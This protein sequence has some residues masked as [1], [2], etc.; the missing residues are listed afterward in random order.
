MI[1]PRAL[2]LTDPPALDDGQVQVWFIASDS[3]PLPRLIHHPS[4]CGAARPASAAFRS[5]THPQRTGEYACGALGRETPHPLG[6]TTPRDGRVVNKAGLPVPPSEALDRRAA[7]VQRRLRQQFVLRLLLGACLG[8]PGRDVALRRTDSGKPELAAAHAA[9]RLHFNISHAGDQL[10]I[11]L[12]RGA[13]VGVDIES[14]AR[15]LRVGPLARRWFA[16]VE[17][18][19]IAGLS[20]EDARREFLERWTT[21]EAVIKA[22]GATIAGHLADVI[23]ADDDPLVLA[24]LPADWPAPSRWTL[25]APDAPAGLVT[26]LAVPAPIESVQSFELGPTA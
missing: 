16:P 12:C 26:R 9:S 21:R 15:A 20:H 17:A 11:A 6:L 25:L 14:T 8:I 3:L 4:H 2:P 5:V 19:R 10:A 18:E 7:L 1:Q 13:A 24:R 22:M 23:P